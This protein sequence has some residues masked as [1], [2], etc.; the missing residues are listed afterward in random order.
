MSTPTNSADSVELIDTLLDQAKTASGGRLLALHHDLARSPAVLAAYMGLRHAGADN[1]TLDPALR[2]AVML[3]V[4]AVDGGD[5]SQAIATQ[6]ALVSG[7]SIEQ[8][9]AVRTAQADDAR[10]AALLAVTR[11]AA[12]NAGLVSDDTWAAALGAGWRDE[13]LVEAFA[14]VALTVFVDYFTNYAR[15]RLDVPP[16]PPIPGGGE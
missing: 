1:G 3:T 15:T 7:M 10:T 11:E 13:Q 6:L 2:A 5:Y 14:Y 16:A 12:A 8:T 4:G 9:V